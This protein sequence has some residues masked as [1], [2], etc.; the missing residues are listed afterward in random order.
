MHKPE[1]HNGLTFEMAQTQVEESKFKA[2]HKFKKFRTDSFAW[3]DLESEAN[4]AIL[5]AWRN[6]NPKESQWNTHATNMLEWK[7]QRALDSTHAVFKMRV[8]TLYDLKK[9]GETLT[10]VMKAKKT[11]DPD[12]NIRY[13]L[14][15]K[16]SMD[17]EV[18]NAYVMEQAY[19]IF[20]V[21]LMNVKNESDMRAVAS[22]LD[23]RTLDYKDPNDFFEKIDKG[24][25]VNNFR[26]KK[27]IIAEMLLKGYGLDSIAKAI[28]M[29][30]FK[31]AEQFG[32]LSKEDLA[33]C[34]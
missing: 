6:W 29:S 8:K 30:K 18:F 27:K 20:G 13:G 7:L 11:K 3:A 34:S 24:L 4:I 25:D 14:D 22:E 9:G 16:K 28:G 5:E 10:S 2:L 26:G 31:M 17:K 23:N 21:G 1:V 12:F 15:G 33:V 32:G 19:K